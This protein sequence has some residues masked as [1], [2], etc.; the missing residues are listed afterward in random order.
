MNWKE[1]LLRAGNDSSMAF[2]IEE[3]F[4]HMAAIWPKAGIVFV[5]DD[6]PSTTCCVCTTVQSEEQ[7]ERLLEEFAI[8]S[9]GWD[10]LDSSKV[11]G[12]L[13]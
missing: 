3:S 5:G 12:V 2:R 6:N 7:I 10:V 11:A 9:T 8:S 4:D 1:A 13:A